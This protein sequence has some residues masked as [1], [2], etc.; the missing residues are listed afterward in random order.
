MHSSLT[1][2]VTKRVLNSPCISNIYIHS[3]STDC[4]NRQ[5]HPTLYFSYSNRLQLTESVTL[6]GQIWTPLFVFYFIWYKIKYCYLQQHFLTE[7]LP[8][9]LGYH[10]CVAGNSIDFDCYYFKK[11]WNNLI[12]SRTIQ[13]SVVNLPAAEFDQNLILISDKATKDSSGIR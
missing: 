2:I 9:L 10:Y 11:S 12:V 4:G 3:R 13:K 5:C 1:D 8:I 6:L 7:L